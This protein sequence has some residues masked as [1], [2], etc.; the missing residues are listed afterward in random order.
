MSG[1]QDP[2]FPIQM[3]HQQPQYASGVPMYAA[4]LGPGMYPVPVIQQTQTA[5]ASNAVEIATPT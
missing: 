1:H 3:H 2:N 4:G 5:R